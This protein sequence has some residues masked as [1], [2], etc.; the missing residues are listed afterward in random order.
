MTNQKSLENTYQRKLYSFFFKYVIYIA[1]L[2]VFLF[3]SFYLPYFFSTSNIVNIF[4]SI[5]VT[6]ILALGITFA[7]TVNDIDLSVAALAGFMSA[8]SAG[9]MV[10]NN[11]PVWLSI[12]VPIIVA[13]LFGA[14]ISL[15]I[16]FFKID[17]LLASFTVL[18]I[19]QGAELT[20]SGGLTIYS[21]MLI[22]S[23][24]GGFQLAEG[25][26]PKSYLFIGQGF[27][28][29]IPM[30]FIIL[31]VFLGI[32]HFFLNNT[33]YGRFLY[34][35]GGNIEAARLAGIPTNRYKFF[36][37]LVASC[38]AAV[39]GILLTSRLGS[40]QSLAA[41]GILLDSIAAAFIGQVI[42]GEKKPNALGTII[43]AI[44]MGVM[45]NGLTMMKVPYTMQDMFKGIIL[46]LALCS[47]RIS[48]S[49]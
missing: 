8:L 41:S 3:F 37:H 43:G 39:G 22:P 32:F 44:F 6:G 38:C 13:C 5:S 29:G 9:L 30:P 49:K 36:A 42:G 33:K 27:I 47:T 31:I 1:L 28:F 35:I 18:F 20:Y 12:L 23:L 7:L 15:L 14:F 21:K 19:A 17:P 46:V 10:F 34:A 16:L 48:F 45:V 25:I 11:G 26:I 4:R 2:V 40:A 24:K